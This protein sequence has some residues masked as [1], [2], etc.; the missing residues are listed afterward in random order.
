[1]RKVDVTEYVEFSEND[2]E[3]L[4]IIKCVCGAKFEA[5]KF[6]ISIYDDNPKAC[7]SCGIKLMFQMALKVYEV[8]P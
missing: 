4:P 2:G 7:P 3:C 8:T 1:M 5:W 6:I